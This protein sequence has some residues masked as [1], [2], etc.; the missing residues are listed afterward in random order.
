MAKKEFELFDIEGAI[1]GEEL[2]GQAK[3]AASQMI[4]GEIPEDVVEQIE[5][6]SAEK[7]IAA[8][9]GM[10]QAARKL[11]ARD[12]GM[13][14]FDISSRGLSL[15]ADLSDTN[16]RFEALKEQR[17]EFNRKLEQ[18]MRESDVQEAGVQLS[19]H[20]LISE[21]DR[22][23]MGLAN[24]LIIKN[25]LNEIQGVQENVDTLLGRGGQEGYFEA[26]N[27]ELLDLIKKYTE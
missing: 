11:T 23:A 1:P 18:S 10:G 25:S 21:N 2:L 15:A 5:T 24:E 13:T 16:L 27:K 8:G 6:I 22:F 17:Y 19:A 9:L 20:Q 26:Q 12:I 3:Q 4:T 14:S 7:G